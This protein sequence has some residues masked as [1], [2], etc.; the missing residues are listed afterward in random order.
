MY[1]HENYYVYIFIVLTYF[2]EFV[3]KKV[4]IKSNDIK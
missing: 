3:Y 2:Q 4:V 1:V